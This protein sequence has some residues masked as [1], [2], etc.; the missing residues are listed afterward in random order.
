MSVQTPRLLYFGTL[1][2]EA[3]SA[4]P[5]QLYRI[6][7][8]VPAD[9]L[10]V[11][12]S[13]CLSADAKLR[14]PGVLY[15]RTGRAFERGW[16]FSRTRAPRIFWQMLELEAWR[17]ARIVA[18]LT[19]SFRPEAV[20]TIHDGFGWFIASR[21]ARRLGV[22]LH[23]ITH[24]EWFRN[25]PMAAALK[26]R[27]DAE[28][29]SLYSGAA[30]RLCISPAM[31]EEYA[32]L[33]G[34]RGTVLYPVRDPRFV[35]PT[36]PASS[37]QESAPELRVAFGGNAWHRGN[38]QSLRDLAAALETIGGKLLLFGPK[39]EDVV[40]HGLEKPNVIVKGF[41]RQLIVDLRTEAHVLFVPMTFEEKERLN[42][43]ICFPS[44][45]TDYSASGLPML[46]QGPD[47]SSPVRWAKENPGAVET[48]TTQG[49]EPLLAAL[50]RLQVP[51]HRE[52]LARMTMQLGEE[53]FGFRNCSKI[54]LEAL[55]RGRRPSPSH[56]SPLGR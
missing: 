27:F 9:K 37:V 54:F 43:A 23:I 20:L 30:S 47:Y 39:R 11:V 25:I 13:D 33:F 17:Q 28:F 24:D 34:S 56:E 41:S 32:R 22:P 40:R 7:Q 15:H 8:S 48:V 3:H 16:Y 55:A 53:Y 36:A 14:I 29:R 4:G 51:S 12:E 38:W 10:C 21:L 44:K 46:V 26:P 50:R 1:P 2:V 35:N 19:A 6:L 45:M 52:K 31:E 49:V 5:M 18:T 42:M